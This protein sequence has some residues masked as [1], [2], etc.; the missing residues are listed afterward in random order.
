M[1]KQLAQFRLKELHATADRLFAE[2]Q[3]QGEVR[4]VEA[5]LKDL[6]ADDLREIGTRL[7]TLAPQVGVVLGS[8]CD[9]KP[10]LLV[11][12]SEAMVKSGAPA[13]GAIVKE[14]GKFIAGGGGGQAHFASAGGKNPAGLEEAVRAAMEKLRG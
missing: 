7:C 11:C 1:R 3:V 9:G 6:N 5:L 12:M 8:L 10:L 4:Y 14:V 13:A 2:A